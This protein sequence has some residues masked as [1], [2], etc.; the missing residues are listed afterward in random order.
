MDYL[1][2]VKYKKGAVVI[3]FVDDPNNSVSLGPVSY[4]IER[5][6]GLET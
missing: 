2:G 3:F 6:P 5:L 4:N 1:G